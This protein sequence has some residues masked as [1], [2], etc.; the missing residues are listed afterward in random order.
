TQMAK[1]RALTNDRQPSAA[2][3]ESFDSHSN[4]FVR[5]E[6][7]HHQISVVCDFTTDERLSVNRRIDY[8]GVTTIVALHAPRND[9]GD[10]CKSVDPSGRFSV[11]HSQIVT[12]GA[13]EQS[14]Q[15]S[16]VFQVLLVQVPKITHRRKTIAEMNSSGHGYYPLGWP[17]FGTD[18]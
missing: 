8:F 18:D 10:G 1:L 7:A 5:N 11:P 12:Q 13:H 3:V 15:G 4:L 2:S 14:R 16:R 17:G 9:A 6:L